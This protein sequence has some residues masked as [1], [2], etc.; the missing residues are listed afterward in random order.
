MQHCCKMSWIAWQCWEFYHP[1]KEKPSSDIC[2]K[3]SSKGGGKMHNIT[4]QPTRFLAMFE[5][6][7]LN[8]FCCPFYCCLISKKQ[9]W[10]V[11]YTFLNI[12]LPLFSM[13]T[14]WN[15]PVRCFMKE[16]PL[17][18]PF[19]LFF[20][21]NSFSPWRPQAFLIFS[22]LLQKLSLFSCN[23][24]C[25]LCFLPLSVIRVRVDIKI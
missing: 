22:L 17:C 8:V 11:Q 5:L 19:C 12:S 14:R 18:V 4:I 16:L 15:F 2:W 6:N 25:F 7:K 23:E 21:A 1:W 24:I 10:H 3:R 20:T 9:T 13:T